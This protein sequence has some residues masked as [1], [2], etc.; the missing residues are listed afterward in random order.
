[1]QLPEGRRAGFSS[2]VCPT[3]MRTAARESAGRKR[4]LI[5]AAKGLL[6]MTRNLNK[7]AAFCKRFSITTSNCKRA[8]PELGQ[9]RVP[10]ARLQLR[11]L[12]TFSPIAYRNERKVSL[13]SYGLQVAAKILS[14]RQP[15]IASHRRWG[16]SLHVEPQ[17]HLQQHRPAGRCSE[18]ASGSSSPRS[19]LRVDPPSGSPQTTLILPRSQ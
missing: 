16:F 7:N 12:S 14:L 2:T 10:P 3:G 4:K 5:A 18:P 15:G 19:L 13:C 11:F 6:R 17:P 1:M 9:R 8:E